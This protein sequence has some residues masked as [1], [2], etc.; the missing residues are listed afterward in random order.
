[1]GE[2]R[3]REVLKAA[4]AAGAS[5][6]HFKP[7]LPP[8]GRIHEELKV[9]PNFGTVLESSMIEEIIRVLI[10]ERSRQ[11]FAQGQEV[12]LA[13]SF[14]G[15]GRFRCNVFR[16][17]GQLGL[18]ARFVPFDIRSL[19]QLGLPAVLKQLSLTPRGLILVT[20]TAGSGKST[21]LAA[22]INEW[23]ETQAGHIIT[24]EDPVEYL[25]RDKRSIVTQREVSLDTE[26]FS[27]GLRSALRQDPDV[28]M[29][30]EMRDRE[31]IQI[32]LNA[33]ETGHL[34]LSTL[35]TRDTLETINR[36]IGIFEPSEQR[37]IRIQFASTL[38]AVV[39]QRILPRAPGP[40]GQ[41]TG[42]VVATEVLVNTPRVRDCLMDPGKTEQIWDAIEDGGAQYGMHSFDQSLLDLLKRGL[43][44]RATAVRNASRPT[45]LELKLRGVQA[46]REAMQEAPV[47]KTAA[48]PATPVA[49]A[50]APAKT[51]A[52]SAVP[53]PRR[54]QTAS[55]VGAAP[56]PGV[57]VPPLA[58]PPGVS[59]QSPNIKDISLEGPGLTMD[60]GKRI[61]VPKPRP[62]K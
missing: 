22:M 54:G 20:G 39:S 41:S 28:I 3:F 34:V 38:T 1:M 13:Y 8:V 15:V 50:A 60:A 12:D 57:G 59:P 21:T 14:P 17:R 19:S 23:N 11:R 30:G 61:L 2:S 52:Q 45:D 56:M 9:L 31:T 49:S 37:E 4:V 10:P 53:L 46:S 43:I 47:A 6:V 33:A 42:V 24:I 35:H 48:A 44:T 32:A 5:D 26:S 18:V 62:P 27:T 55:G 51:N 29:I 16:Y 7:G 36:V 25:F 40:E 58:R